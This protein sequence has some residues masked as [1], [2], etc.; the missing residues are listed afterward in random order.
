MSIT[1]IISYYKALDRLK[2]I[3]KALNHQTVKDFCVILSEDDFNEET[4]KFLEA[5]STDYSFKIQHINQPKDIGFRK[6]MM[7]N[8]AVLAAK[9][10]Y[11]V[12]IDGDCVP[13]KHFVKE[14]IKNAKPKTIL[15]GR[16]VMLD[17]K[18][19]GRI[20]QTESLDYLRFWKILFSGSAKKKEALYFPY[21]HLSTTTR[22]LLGANWGIA[23][24][25]VLDVNG[26][27]EDYQYPG[28]GEDN[29]IDWRLKRNG[30]SVKS[31]KNKAI[32]F[33]LYHPRSYA[34][35]G[36]KKN[37]QMLDRKMKENLIFCASG[38]HK[39]EQP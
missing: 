37:F 16:R 2:I 39:K 32:V 27:D 34:Q 29:D 17:E 6:N 33:H 21:F 22:G 7:L 20:L 11:L 38:I 30:L 25:D 23:K 36:V 15:N 26:F 13:Q 1:I 3:L 8:K 14:Y 9:T 18:I 31:M 28:V 5:N 12:F 19:T 24:Q 35:D 4:N 10:D